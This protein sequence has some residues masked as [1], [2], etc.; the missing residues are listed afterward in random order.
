MMSIDTMV[1]MIEPVEDVESAMLKRCGGCCGGV[2]KFGRLGLSQ[3][4]L[5]IMSST[6]DFHSI[7][8]PMLDESVPYMGV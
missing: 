3:A 6:K 1:K 5:S 8:L 7:C 4:D 2:V